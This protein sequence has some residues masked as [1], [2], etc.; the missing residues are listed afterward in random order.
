VL[1]LFWRLFASVAATGHPNRPT[2]RV[3]IGECLCDV[4]EAHLAC[5][6]GRTLDLDHLVL[7]SQGV[8]EAAAVALA[9]CS[10]CEAVMLA[11][12][13]G[14]R[15]QRCCR[16]QDAATAA[17]LRILVPAS[18]EA[19]EIAASMGEGVQQDLF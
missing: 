5:F 15:R 10:S 1:A 11:D 19:A 18:S 6:P 9:R 8:D 2:S 4:F 3:E 14:L 13:L 17:P 12:L 7:L 16:C